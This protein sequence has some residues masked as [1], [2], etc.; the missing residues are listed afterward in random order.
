MKSK[1]LLLLTLVSVLGLT[2]FRAS[3]QEPAIGKITIG[4][5]L[6]VGD[7]MNLIFTGPDGT[8]K[9]ITV[10][11]AKQV[12]VEGKIAYE[13]TQKPV[14]IT[15]D[16][17]TFECTMSRI[18]TLD[19]DNCV[20]LTSLI[21]GTNALKQ[22]DLTGLPALESLDCTTA[23][24]NTIILGGNDKL[25]SI[26]ADANKLKSINLNGAPNLESVS[27]PINSLTEIDLDGVSC[28]SLDVSNNA[29]TSLDL[30][31]TS[32][33]EWLSVSSNPL[34]SI[35]LTG[36]TALVN[37]S[38]K[39]TKLEEIDLTG[40]TELESL[41]LHA[42]KLNKITFGENGELT[43]IDLSNN[44]LSSIDF[45]ECPK[46][47]YLSLNDNEFTEMHLKGL[48]ELSSINL[49]FNKLTNFSIEDC[50]SLSSVVVSDNLLTSV[51][52]TGGKDNLS[53]VYVGGNQL[54]TL[55]LS[56][57][58]SLSTLSAENNQLTSVNLE[59]CSNLYSLN[60]GGNKFT[61]LTL[62]E[63]PSLGE[64]YIENNNIQGDAMMALMKSLPKKDVLTGSFSGSIY[65]VET[66]SDKEQNICLKEH[67]E[68]AHEQ[69]WGVYDKR[70]WSNYDGASISKITTKTEGKGG[71]IMVNGKTQLDEV[72]SDTKIVITDNHDSGYA[73]NT[74]KKVSKGDTIDIFKDRYFYATDAD[75][76]V[77]ATFT[78]DVC[79]VVLKKLGQ[80]TLK[81]KGDGLD[82]KGLPR[83]MEIELIAETSETSDW[84]L[85]D[86]KVTNLKTGK[87]TN[88]LSS[89]SFKLTDDMEVFAEFQNANGE[90]PGDTLTW[91]GEQWL[92]VIMPTVP[93]SEEAQLYPNPATDFVT[94]A[95]AQPATTV[96]IYT[97]SGELVR[98]YATS[99]EGYA[100]LSVADLPE[101]TYIVL[102]GNDPRKLI[103]RR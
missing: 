80:G 70:T 30:S 13:I 14:T 66:R 71:S 58:A 64:V 89:K 98:S 92:G 54:T 26:K 84:E 15:G 83:G 75:V 34:T 68:A 90:E 102:I 11:G 19:F 4:T 47:K 57:F 1:L 25:K 79:K 21:C 41:D 40:L 52:L 3:A 99:R 27:L 37:F 59:N 23:E 85:S 93:S 29:L 20:N 33:L 10:E 24:I 100:E 51:D 17:R 60:L 39:T 94:I 16:I 65:A 88:I 62:P 96:N 50:P 72:Y 32:N 69:G 49:R 97:L 48:E 2:A 35:N 28:T 53:D 22:L 38:A 87:K 101:G 78:D 45:K 43:D 12:M 81:L 63:L 76:E 86:L 61:A 31:K 95:G 77:V 5:E 46:L 73:L 36:C 8:L 6:N 103:I 67:V 82:T 18:T 9:D 74:L 7:R 55:D 42:G 91:N 56:G 44:K